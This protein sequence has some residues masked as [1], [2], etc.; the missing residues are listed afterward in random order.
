M[1]DMLGRLLV[2]ERRLHGLELYHGRIPEGPIRN[3]PDEMIHHIFHFLTFSELLSCEQCA[4][5]SLFVFLSLFRVCKSWQENVIFWN[6]HLNL[7]PFADSVNE[8]VMR[9]VL[10]FK[11]VEELDLTLCREVGNNMAP[12]IAAAFPKL[13]RL[14][15]NG[16]SITAFEHLSNL[17]ALSYLHIGDSDQIT[18][19]TLVCSRLFHCFPIHL[20]LIR[21]GQPPR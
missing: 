2:A 19:A 21:L 6:R 10:K 12:L 17:P 16:T 5:S 20:V 3:I 9:N 1:A 11:N 13:S 8:G 7:A 14:V 18:D 15:M 4:F